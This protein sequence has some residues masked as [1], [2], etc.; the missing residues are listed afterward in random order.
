VFVVG[1]AL[2]PVTTGERR[3]H[4]TCGATSRPSGGA[5]LHTPPGCPIDLLCTPKE[6][7]VMLD[8]ARRKVRVPPLARWLLGLGIAA[9]LA[10]NVAH[11]LGHGRS[12]PGEDTTSTRPEPATTSE[13]RKSI[14]KC[15]CCSTRGVRDRATACTLSTPSAVMLEN[16]HSGS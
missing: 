6:S 5:D 9:T 11:G 7:M 12:P 10:A 16:I 4:N 2:T 15:C 13:D 1:A 14:T 3:S 8:S